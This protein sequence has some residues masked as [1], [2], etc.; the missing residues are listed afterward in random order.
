[1]TLEAKNRLRNKRASWGA[2]LSA[3]TMLLTL[4]CS[5]PDAAHYTKSEPAAVTE[6][7]GEAPAA[8]VPELSTDASGRNPQ[9][10]AQQKSD[11]LNVINKQQALITKLHQQARSGRPAPQ[12]VDVSDA[13]SYSV[14]DLRTIVAKQRKVI[15]ALQRN[16][17]H[18]H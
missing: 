12:L 4:S 9:E 17:A 14:D 7:I 3:L 5:R 11:L 15:S 1:M 18:P 10:I 16:G 13:D 6:E 8:A 2:T